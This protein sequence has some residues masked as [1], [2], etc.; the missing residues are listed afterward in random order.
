MKFNQSGSLKSHERLHTGEK[1]F[2]CMSCGKSFADSGS[3]SKH[4]KIHEN[5]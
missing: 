5:A 4:I 2:N 3:Y 1:P